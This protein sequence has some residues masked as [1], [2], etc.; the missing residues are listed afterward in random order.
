MTPQTPDIQRKPISLLEF[1]TTLKHTSPNGICLIG[2]SSRKITDIATQVASII[3][4]IEKDPQY[5]LEQIIRIFGFP[6]GIFTHSLRE[7]LKNLDDAAVVTRAK[8]ELCGI[9][10][11]IYETI[12]NMKDKVFLTHVAQVYGHN[13]KKISVT[14]PD[15]LA[16]RRIELM[17]WRLDEIRV[18]Q[19]AQKTHGTVLTLVS[20][21]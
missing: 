9:I 11:P 8:Q 13:T 15:I 4:N 12:R 19:I 6:E 14:T 18:Q 7:A 10:D 16:Q 3:E 21:I 20:S 1:V 2:N 17:N 5:D